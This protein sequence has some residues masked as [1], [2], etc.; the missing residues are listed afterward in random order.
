VPINKIYIPPGP[1]PWALAVAYHYPQLQR[2]LDLSSS[3]SIPSVWIASAC[4]AIIKLRQNITGEFFCQ[5]LLSHV[6]ILNFAIVLKARA[7]LVLFLNP[8]ICTLM[9]ALMSWVTTTIPKKRIDWQYLSEI[10][11][12]TQEYHD[13]KKWRREGERKGKMK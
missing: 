10:R 6:C 8:E 12:I 11:R 1:R 13:L 3:D 9:R 5:Y 7:E 2:H 4:P